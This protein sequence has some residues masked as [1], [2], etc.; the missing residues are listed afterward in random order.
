[1]ARPLKG[2]MIANVDLSLFLIFSF[3]LSK[4]NESYEKRGGRERSLG[5][6]RPGGLKTAG[7]VRKVLMAD[8]PQTTVPSGHWSAM[9]NTF[10]LLLH[11]LKVKKKKMTP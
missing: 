5:P 2:L 7:S 9:N 1:M 6:L 4:D 11:Y 8:G 3:S 10:L